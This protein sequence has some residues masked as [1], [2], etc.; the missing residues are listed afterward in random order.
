MNRDT[1]YCSPRRVENFGDDSSR[2]SAAS[3]PANARIHWIV[4]ILSGT[5]ARCRLEG[6]KLTWAH[7]QSRS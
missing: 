2:H 3:V 6:N 1:G 4:S 7:R 5:Q